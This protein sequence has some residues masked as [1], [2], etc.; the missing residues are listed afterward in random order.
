MSDSSLQA[1]LHLGLHFQVFDGSL[2]D[3]GLDAAGGEYRGGL[4]GLTGDELFGY[5][6]PAP[7]LAV[8]DSHS[9][10]LN[11]LG[12]VGLC[13][14]LGAELEGAA[15]I[16]PDRRIAL[17]EDVVLDQ[18]DDVPVGQQGVGDETL[19]KGCV[20]LRPPSDLAFEHRVGAGGPFLAVRSLAGADA[21]LGDEDV[22]LPVDGVC[23]QLGCDP[24]GVALVVL[25][26]PPRARVVECGKG[27]CGAPGRR[28]V[29]QLDHPVVEDSLRGHRSIVPDGWEGPGPV[30]TSLAPCPAASVTRMDRVRGV[31][32]RGFCCSG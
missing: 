19:G 2:G 4:L 20:R 25:D 21:G 30:F 23:E 32:D 12:T 11:H 3:E 18:A 1:R 22:E 28:G 26:Q 31:E 16:D 15:L 14:S 17:P 7:G 10:E 27:A 13:V 24:V 9:L 5:G 8:P 29:R 6:H